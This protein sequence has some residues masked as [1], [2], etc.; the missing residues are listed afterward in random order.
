M[1]FKQ[2]AGSALIGRVNK[3]ERMVRGMVA[4]MGDVPLTVK[5]RT[6]IYNNQPTAHTL[7]PKLRDCGVQMMTVWLL[8]ICQE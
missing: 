3:F 5:T 8:Q 2:G 4:V 1:I 7:I 6:G